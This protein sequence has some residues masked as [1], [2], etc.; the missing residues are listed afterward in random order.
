MQGMFLQ[1]ESISEGSAALL[2]PALL[3]K[4]RGGSAGCARGRAA[5]RGGRGQKEG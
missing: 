1:L 3:L 5:L 2:I 4:R